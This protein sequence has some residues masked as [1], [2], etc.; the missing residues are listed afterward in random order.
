M[1]RKLGIVVLTGASAGVGRATAAM[2]AKRGCKIGLIAR[3]AEPL[4]ETRAMVEAAGGEAIALPLDVADAAAVD[5]AAEQVETRFGPIDTWINAAMVTVFSPVSEMTAEEFR[6]VT[7]VTYLGTVHGTLAALKRMRQRDYGTIV[8]VGS[9]LSYRSI[10]L[11]SAYCGAKFAIRGF[12]DALRSELIH[13]GSRIRLSMVQL[14]G[15]NT[16]QF[17]WARN[18]LPQ[19]PRPVAPVYQPEVAARAIVRAAEEAPRELWVGGSSVQA[20]L[21]TMVLPGLLDRLLAA[22]AYSGQQTSEPALERADN[23][24]TSY[25]GKHRAHGRFGR[26]ARTRAIRLSSG[27]VR[28]A[29]LGTAGA[30]VAATSVLA[31]QSRRA[32]LEKW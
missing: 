5:A 30:A 19:R 9:A 14:P 25:P 8:Q 7:E 16:P 18:H 20:I 1:R 10:P 22:R 29:L 28:A 3:G 21:G 15:L 2:L 27:T 26:H 17:E 13:D 23:L 11:Q 31:A 4:E 24:E 6:R 12:T 32:R